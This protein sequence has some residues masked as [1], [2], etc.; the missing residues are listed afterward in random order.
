MFQKF[1][2]RA[3][4]I[5]CLSRFDV[6]GKFE[7]PYSDPGTKSQ[8]TTGNTLLILRKIHCFQ[9]HK[10]KSILL[11]IAVIIQIQIYII[12]T[13]PPYP[14]IEYSER[15]MIVEESI[16]NKIKVF[17]NKLLSR[18]YLALNLT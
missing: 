3:L 17:I 5:I 11:F 12:A 8:S 7:F 1:A 9:Y 15:I 6:F 14:N 4:L 16:R 2:V 10:K 13:L 18:S